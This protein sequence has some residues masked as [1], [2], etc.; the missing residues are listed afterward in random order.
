MQLRNHDDDGGSAN[1]EESDLNAGFDEIP[2]VTK[3]FRNNL[4][5]ADIEDRAAADRVHLGKGIEIRE[6]MFARTAN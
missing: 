1:P 6:I 3:R 4:G 5:Q 2:F